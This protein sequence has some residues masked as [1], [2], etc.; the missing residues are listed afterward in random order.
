MWQRFDLDTIA[1]MPWR[2]G[3][4][5]TRELACWPPGASMDGFTARLSLATVA[6]DGP[7]SRF[8]G[9]DRWITLLDGPGLRLRSRPGASV[10]AIDHALSAPF[11]PYAFAGEAEIDATLLGGASTDFNLMLCRGAGRATLQVLREAASLDGASDGLLLAWHGRWRCRLGADEVVCGPR[12]GL[13]WRDEV[14]AATLDARPTGADAADP[15]SVGA[16]PTDAPAVVSANAPALHANHP[17]LLVVCL[18]FGAAARAGS[19][20]RAHAPG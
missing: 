12:Q 3:G 15:P 20:P 18:D 5:A 8:P 2:N 14:P 1:P 6:A 9:V 16:V 11:E 19:P 4:G 17:V 13:W 10:P 7:F